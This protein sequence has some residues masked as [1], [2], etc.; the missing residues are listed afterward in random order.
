LN[1]G[2]M[3]EESEIIGRVLNGD[4]EAFRVLV[5]RYQGPIVR[6]VRNLVGSGWGCEDLAQE[7]FLA[8]YANLRTYDAAKSRFSTWLF[9]IARNKCVNAFKKKRP[10]T[11]REL[12]ERADWTGPVEDVARAEL[13]AQ[14]D[15]ALASLPAEQRTAFV[16]VTFEGLS[17]EEVA[18]IEKTR[19]GT[20]KSR[21]NRAKAKLAEALAQFQEDRS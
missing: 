4:T 18:Q 19:I 3:A 2:D 10:A 11:V 7:V 1:P 12:P 20:V 9:T 6:I 15:V 16:L 8:A 21:I 17:Y 5:E 14:L 13:F